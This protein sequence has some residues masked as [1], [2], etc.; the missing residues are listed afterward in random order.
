MIKNTSLLALVL[1]ILDAPTSPEIKYLKLEAGWIL[2]NIAY[3]SKDVLNMLFNEHFIRVIN[4]VL[5]E[6]PCD[7]QMV[8]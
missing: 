6:Q 3:G 2:T 7:I 8:D 1:Q 5:N 4:K